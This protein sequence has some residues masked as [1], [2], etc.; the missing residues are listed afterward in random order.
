MGKA[1]LECNGVHKPVWLVKHGSRS[2]WLCP[3]YIH[4]KKHTDKVFILKALASDH[5]IFQHEP[6]FGEKI[7]VTSG[8]DELKLWK[9]KQ[10]GFTKACT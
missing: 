1:W 9:K 2:C 5:C 7:V 4:Q 8:L 6:L 10:E 3:R